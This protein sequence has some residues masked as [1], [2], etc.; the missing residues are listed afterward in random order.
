MRYLNMFKNKKGQGIS[1]N[2]IIIATIALLVL[3]I[4]S[5]L[6]VRYVSQLVIDCNEISG[7]CTDENKCSD[8]GFYVPKEAK[9]PMDDQICC[10]PLEQSG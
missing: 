7:V 6:L 2:T 10:I 8:L 3:V 9:C 1:I 4:L 5:V